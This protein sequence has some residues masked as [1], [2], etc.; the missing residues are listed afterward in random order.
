MVRLG[1][2]VQ[3]LIVISGFGSG[4]E[5]LLLESRNMGS[6]H[7]GVGSRLRMGSVAKARSS[8]TPTG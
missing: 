4:L 6:H 5:M 8:A 2:E 3:I 7:L 1:R